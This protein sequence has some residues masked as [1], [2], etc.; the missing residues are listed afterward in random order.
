MATLTEN[1]DGEGA[2]DVS[3]RLDLFTPLAVALSPLEMFFIRC[4]GLFPG[5]IRARVYKAQ[6]SKQGF[7]APSTPKLFTIAQKGSGAWTLPVEKKLAL[8]AVPKAL[9]CHHP[10]QLRSTRHGRILQTSYVQYS[11]LRKPQLR[12]NPLYGHRLSD[13]RKCPF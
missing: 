3:S 8:R 4:D 2:G 12:Y 1:A 11:C 6:S 10:G 9:P 13:R 7:V 5:Q